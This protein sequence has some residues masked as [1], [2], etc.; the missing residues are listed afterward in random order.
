VTYVEWIAA[1]VTRHKG[2]VRGLCALAC[3]NMRKEFPE[4]V[5]VR[6]WANGCEHAWLTAPDGAVVDPTAAQFEGEPI[7]Y[8]PFKPGDAVRVGRCH[9]CGDGIYA[10][11]DRLDD[12]K[13]ARSICNPCA[14]VPEIECV[15]CGCDLTGCTDAEKEP[16]C[17][18]CREHHDGLCG[19]DCPH[20]IHAERV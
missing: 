14:G 16:R 20:T 4:L 2:H 15:D 18:T 7:V 12:P 8:V 17:D 6:G 1:C 10:A 9:E 11:V 5:E 19:A 3:A 13:H